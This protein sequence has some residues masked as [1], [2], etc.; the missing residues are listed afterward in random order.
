MIRPRPDCGQ[1]VTNHY[2]RFHRTALFKMAVSRV[3]G[4]LLGRRQSGEHAEYDLVAGIDRP[5][6]VFVD[7]PIL[8]VQQH[9]VQFLAQYIVQLLALTLIQQ[10]ADHT[11]APFSNCHLYSEKTRCS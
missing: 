7:S 4:Q 2:M 11:L 10:K 3:L 6:Y 8:Q 1:D 5:P 9:L